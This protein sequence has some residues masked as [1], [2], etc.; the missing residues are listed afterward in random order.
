MFNEF[1]RSNAAIADEI[2]FEPFVVC[3]SCTW[4]DAPPVCGSVTTRPWL[5]PDAVAGAD[6]VTLVTVVTPVIVVPCARF[7]ASRVLKNLV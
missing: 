2:V 3:M 5:V 4:T 1:V 7:V 6:T